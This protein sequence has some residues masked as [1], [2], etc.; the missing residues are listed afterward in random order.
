VLGFDRALMTLSPRDF[1]TQVLINR[2]GASHVS[3][4][5]NFRYGQGRAGDVGT[6]KADGDALCFGVTIVEP[7]LGADGARISST[8]VREALQHGDVNA[9]TNM[10]TRPWA[11]EG[12]VT[13]GFQRGRDFG[14]PTL[15]IPLGDYLAPKLGVYAV[16][17][18]L[19]GARLPGVASIGVNPTVGTLPAPVLEAHIF[20]FAA[21]LYG[22][23]A[24]VEI[25]AFLRPEEKF[26]STDAL[27]AQMAKDTEQ[28]RTLLA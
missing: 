10:L 16:R 19:D 4:G 9:A 24:E 7:V 5:A 6:L 8:A 18:R 28:A 25:A 27:K 20:D 11:I 17:V 13:R 2:L 21:D 23:Q 22:R 26:D 1:A 12:V 3:V 14:F 15:N